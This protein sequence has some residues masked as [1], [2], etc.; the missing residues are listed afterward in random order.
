MPLDKILHFGVGFLLY[1]IMYGIY[2]FANIP[3]FIMGVP[4]EL[5]VLINVVVI[6]IVKEFADKEVKHSGFNYFDM[7]STITGGIAGLFAT[8]FFMIFVNI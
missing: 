6:G 8:M 2:Y 3:V 1:V 5:I 7:L 4:V